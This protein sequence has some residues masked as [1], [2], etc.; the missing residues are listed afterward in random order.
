MEFLYKTLDEK[1]S[2][3]LKSF[4]TFKMP[5]D[6]HKLNYA[7]KKGVINSLI[8][9]GSFVNWSDPTNKINISMMLK[10]IF[11]STK[12]KRVWVIVTDLHHN[13]NDLLNGEKSDKSKTPINFLKIN[14]EGKKYFDI[15]AWTYE[16]INLSKN[17]QFF[18]P[19]LETENM[20]EIN[21]KNQ[22][23]ETQRILRDSF[24]SRMDFHHCV[25]L[26]EIQPWSSLFSKFKFFKFS[27]QGAPYSSRILM[28]NLLEQNNYMSNYYNYLDRFLNVLIT[29]LV[30]VSET[31][32]HSLRARWVFKNRVRFLK[33]LFL[34]G[35]SRYSYV[36]GSYL[37]YPVRK[38]FEFPVSNS[39]VI[40]PNTDV[41]KSLGF[42][43]KI[44]C[45]LLEKN[46][47]IEEIKKISNIS[48][49]EY[50]TILLASRKLI[51]DNHQVTHR[52]EQLLR[53]LN[54]YDRN[55]VVRGFFVN[56][57]FKIKVVRRTD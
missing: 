11:V 43:D 4:K 8:L 39:V 32:F 12:T 37:N 5:E 27:I 20:I 34:A 2:P 23:I 29:Y 33:Q 31:F 44:N 52:V 35:I 57:T 41:L 50:S 21:T 10:N 6:F 13:A 3:N 55:S 36:D 40:S 1:S 19:S 46:T 53:Y 51:S 49:S 15:L 45:F 9:V 14:F 24:P 47:A 54:N 48:A 18:T 26:K 7:I 25:D 17:S 16:L 22:F 42:K 38:Y 56:G 28:R 30:K